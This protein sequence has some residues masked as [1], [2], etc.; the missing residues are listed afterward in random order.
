VFSMDLSIRQ[1]E[2]RVLVALRGEL[3]VADA[4]SAAAALIAL[5]ARGCEIVV[6]LASL[7]FIDSSGLAALVLARGHARQAG[8]DLLLAAPRQQVLRVL[9]V[10]RLIEAFA[11]HACAEIDGLQRGTPMAAT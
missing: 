5:A 8:G 3:D 7:D 1:S 2:D 10:T 11:V 6:D 4:A 9:T